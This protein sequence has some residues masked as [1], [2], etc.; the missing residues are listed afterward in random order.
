MNYQDELSKGICEVAWMDSSSVEYVQSMT[1]SPNHVT[2]DE[3]DCDIENNSKHHIV[4][5]NMNDEKWQKGPVREIV[6]FE[7]L[8]GIGIKDPTETM[9]ID[10]GALDTILGMCAEDYLEED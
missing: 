9:T 1:T 10:A 4:A 5:W 2:K 6:N 7:R 3:P 8:T